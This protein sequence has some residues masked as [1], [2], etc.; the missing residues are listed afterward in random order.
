MPIYDQYYQQE[1]Y[2]GQPYPELLAYF[3]REDKTASIL[4]VGCGQGR[5]TLALGRLG[6]KVLGIDVSSVGIE[7]LNHMAAEEKLQVKGVMMDFHAMTHMDDYDIILLDSIFH[8]YKKDLEQET[9]LLYRL[10]TQMKTQ[11]RLVLVIQYHP[12]RIAFFRQILFESHIKT[13]IIH[14]EIFLYKEFN[15]RFILFVINK[16]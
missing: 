2:F 4:D 8:F 1:Q 6:F 13:S 14:E 10:M 12:K 7:Q 15:R 16:E 9:K 5:D 11:G 3:K